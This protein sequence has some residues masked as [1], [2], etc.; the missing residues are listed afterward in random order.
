MEPYCCM[1]ACECGVCIAVC[2]HLFM[3]Q[4]YVCTVH[5]DQSLHIRPTKMAVSALSSSLSVQQMSYLYIFLK[6]FTLNYINV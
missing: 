2:T 4:V 6:L 3:S 1:D 5:Y